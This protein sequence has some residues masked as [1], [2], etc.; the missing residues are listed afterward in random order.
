MNIHDLE[1]RLAAEGCNPS[2][3]A[4]GQRGPASDAYCLTHNGKEWQVYYT[5]RGSDQPPIFSAADEQQACEYFFNFIMK[6]RHDHCVGF[7]RSKSA[8]D[9]LQ[10]ALDSHGFDS[11]QDKIPYGGFSDPRYRVFVTGKAIFAARDILEQIPA[12]D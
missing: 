4:I 2:N 12:N 1:Q 9:A 8:A 11:H 5:E 7:F 6:M 10:A 3:Y